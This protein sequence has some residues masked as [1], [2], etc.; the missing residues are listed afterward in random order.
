M[1][2][3][4]SSILTVN[5][6][7]CGSYTPDQFASLVTL[8][9]LKRMV[10]RAEEALR[11]PLR[12]ELLRLMHS[13]PGIRMVEMYVVQV[14]PGKYAYAYA[15]SSRYGSPPPSARLVP[16]GTPWVYGG[17][18]AKIRRKAY[19]RPADWIHRLTLAWRIPIKFRDMAAALGIKGCPSKGSVPPSS[20]LPRAI[21]SAFADDGND[22][23][24][25][26]TK[27][28]KR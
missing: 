4:P 27:R 3:P 19:S 5:T 25:A 12:A 11:A 26:G 17:W 6:S 15:W 9:A 13:R 24:V 28:K 23:S 22:D 20:G 10:A 7:N 16:K 18:Y 2:L 8:N 21:S 1:A 14:K